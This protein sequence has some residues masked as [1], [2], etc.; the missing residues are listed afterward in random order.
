MIDIVKECEGA[1]RVVITG[2]TNPDGDCVGSV[3]A[4]WQF[5]KKALQA[6]VCVMLEKP[7]PIFEFINGVSE[8]VMDYE[9]EQVYDVLFVLDSVCDRTGSAQ[10]YIQ[11]AKKVINIDHHVSN[12]G[13]GGVNEI[14]PKASSTAEMIYR[15]ISQKPEY[16]NLIDKEMAQTIYIGIIHDSGVMQYSNTSPHTM[17]IVA[18]LI[19]YGFDFPKLIDETFYEKTYIQSQIM[20]RAILEAFPLL[21]GKCMVSMVDRKTMAFYGA[22]KQDLSG[23]VNQLRIVKGVEVAIFMYEIETLVY[24]VSLRSCSYVDVACVAAYFEG[25]GHVR[26]AGCTM[27]GSFYDVV[28]NLMDQISLQITDTRQE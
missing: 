2:H 13:C 11:T 4:L 15:L 12:P 19:E 9:T 14:D 20:G 27:N 3:M 24:K 6:D 16:K 21:D 7:A 26:A 1:A 22:Q 25:G 28:N 18:D 8:I 5:L 23:I 17:R 10:K